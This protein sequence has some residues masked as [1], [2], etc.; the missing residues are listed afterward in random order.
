VVLVAALVAVVG[1][2]YLVSRRGPVSWVGAVLAAAGLLTLILTIV[3]AD[4]RG[5]PFI[6]A[7]VLIALSGSAARYALHGGPRSRQASSGPGEAVGPA[8]HPVLLINPKSGGG[9]AERFRLVEECGA[10]GIEPVVLQPGDDLLALATDAIKRADVIGM[11]GGD[12]SQAL[13]ASVAAEHDIPHVC[14]PAGTRNHFALDLG[15]DREDVVGALDAFGD[16]MERRIDLAKVNGRVFVNNACM[17]LY[18]KIVQS[19]EYRDAK[20]KTAADMLPDLL[21]PKAEP[22][23]LRFIGP[24]EQECPS[25][26]LLLVSNDP[27]ELVHIGGFGTRKRIDLGTLGL[28][29][30]RID[31]TKDAV[32]FVGMEAAGRIRNFHGWMEWESRR[33]QVDSGE[34]IEIGID[35]E[36]MTLDPPLVFESVPGAL[37]VRIPQHAPGVAPAATS[38]QLTTSTIAELARTAVG[39]P[40]ARS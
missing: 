10:R 39:R 24:D 36:A 40:V 17:G 27:Y 18:A 20:L 32:T 35:G 38:V 7:I 4:Y 2:W 8:N 28:V 30:A 23:D 5:L 1:L 21:G 11:A 6:L 33:F 37:R 29:A 31:G 25:A 14:I 15:I 16:A 19:K 34:P 13:V 3:T 9:K 12:G 26:H 22:F